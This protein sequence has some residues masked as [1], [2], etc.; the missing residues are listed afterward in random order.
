M[1][2]SI[3]KEI[4]KIITARLLEAAEEFYSRAENIQAFKKWTKSKEAK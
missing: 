3:V 4:E 2:I 1:Q